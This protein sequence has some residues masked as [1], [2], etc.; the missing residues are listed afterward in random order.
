M[1]FARLLTLFSAATLVCGQSPEFAR[2]GPAPNGGD[3]LHTG[4]TLKPAGREV[5]LGPFPMSAELS[6]SGKFLLVMDSG[7]DKPS[8]RVLETKTFR[9]IQ[10]L[11]L[12]GAWL[13]MDFTVAGNLV[14]V[15]GG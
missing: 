6:P 12:D 13:G 10:R 4:W 15:S 11:E 8:I 3:L 14:Y 5:K 9:E 7:P 1:K 2:P